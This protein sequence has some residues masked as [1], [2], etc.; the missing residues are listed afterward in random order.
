MDHDQATA[1][2]HGLMQVFSHVHVEGRY[3]PMVLSDGVLALARIEVPS[4]TSTVA[5][6]HVQ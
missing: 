5:R 1:C 4:F 6:T 2:V 3:I